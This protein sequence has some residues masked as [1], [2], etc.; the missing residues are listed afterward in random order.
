MSSPRPHRLP[1]P[2]NDLLMQIWTEAVGRRLSPKEAVAFQQASEYSAL[3]EHLARRGAA[4]V[5][6]RG[7]SMIETSARGTRVLRLARWLAACDAEAQ[8][9]SGQVLDQTEATEPAQAEE[10]WSRL[11]NRRLT[12]AL[13]RNFRARPHAVSIELLIRMHGLE[14]VANAGQR[15]IRGSPR[16]YLRLNVW[17]REVLEAARERAPH[18]EPSPSKYPPLQYGDDT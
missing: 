3:K 4:F 12:P 17:H 1:A 2:R 7:K 5:S 16:G 11:T 14:L 10:L 8:A 13:Q 6:V 9:E 15:A 18:V